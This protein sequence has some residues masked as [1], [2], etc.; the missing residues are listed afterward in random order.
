MASSSAAV[1]TAAPP[2]PPPPPPPARRIVRLDPS[3]VNRI[4]AGEVIQ[5]PSSALKEM[6][7]NCLD[8]GSTAI[9]VA[10]KA[11]GLKVLQVTDNGCGIAVSVGAG[12][13]AHAHARQLGPL[14]TLTSPTAAHLPHAPAHPAPT[15]RRTTS[16][17]CASASRRPS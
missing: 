2:V 16:R 13:G 4:A 6:L 7:E 10:V 5:R 12:R 1:V 14:R 17:W 9:T 8:A 3:V 11:G 15:R